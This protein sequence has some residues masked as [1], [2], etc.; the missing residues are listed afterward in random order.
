MVDVVHDKEVAHVQMS[1]A[2]GAQQSAILL[3]KDGTLVILVK[4][5]FLEIKTL[6]M[7]K[8]ICPKHEWH[9][10]IGSNKLS[11]G[12]TSSVEL[13]L[14]RAQHNHAFA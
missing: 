6:H 3:E 2:L 1:C 7:Q 14:E 12:G 13:L 11:L 5:C 10:I 8:V 9:G 4:D